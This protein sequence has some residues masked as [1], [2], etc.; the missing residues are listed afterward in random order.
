MQISRIMINIVAKIS[1][2]F[3]LRLLNNYISNYKLQ[4]FEPFFVFS[5][6]PKKNYKILNLLYKMKL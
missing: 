5:L 3:F 6:I 2:Y 1:K 4:Y